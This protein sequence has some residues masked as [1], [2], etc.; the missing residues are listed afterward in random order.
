MF[1]LRLAI[2][3]KFTNAPTIALF[4]G[5]SMGVVMEMHIIPLG[6]SSSQVQVLE[7]LK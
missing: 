6:K 7:Q 1:N 2:G 3:A 5:D 4:P